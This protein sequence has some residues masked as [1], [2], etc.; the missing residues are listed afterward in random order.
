MRNLTILE[1][2]NNSLIELPL[3]IQNM[4]NLEEIDISGNKFRCDCDTFWMTGWLQN[5]KV[6]DPEDIICAL[7]KGQGKILIDLNQADAGCN[8]PLILALICLAVAVVPFT[9]DTEGI[10][11]SCSTQYLVS[12]HGIKF[13]NILKKKSMMLLCLITMKIGIGF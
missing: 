6:K 11:K 2:A 1:L 13:R 4:K 8:D 3:S 7:G 9:I 12:I 10:L 5:T